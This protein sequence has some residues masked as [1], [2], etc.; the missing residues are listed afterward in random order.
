LE[1]KDN[2]GKATS[3]LFPTDLSANGGFAQILYDFLLVISL[4]KK[5]GK[6]RSVEIGV[7]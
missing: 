6:K 1:K 5:I 2:M 7:R 4:V 3:Y